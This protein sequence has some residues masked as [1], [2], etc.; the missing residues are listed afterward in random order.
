[1][2]TNTT[3]KSSSSYI[4]YTIIYKGYELKKSTENLE[5]LGIV[6]YSKL[7]L[8]SKIGKP[9]VVNRFIYIYN[10]WGYTTYDEC[11]S[12]I[13]NKDI[14]VMGYGIYTSDRVASFSA[15]AKFM[16]GS[17]S[18]NNVLF[19]KNIQISKNTNDDNNALSITSDSRIHKFLF[20]KPIF[21]KAN[22]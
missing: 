7:F 8:I 16:L 5:K 17:V 19:Q 12:F 9:L 4:E 2:F 18:D 10:G 3:N 14:R 21:C 22:L 13:T 11:I 1:M 6:P 15:T 20:D